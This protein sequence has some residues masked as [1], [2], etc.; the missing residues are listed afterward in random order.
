MSEV[1]GEIS[2]S[3]STGKTLYE[4]FRKKL[5]SV[6]RDTFHAAIKQSKYSLYSKSTRAPYCKTIVFTIEGL[7]LD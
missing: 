3:S 4:N 2:V 7:E 6:S 1:S 5:T